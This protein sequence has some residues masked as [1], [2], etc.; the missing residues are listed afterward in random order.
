MH[1]IDFLPIEYRVANSQRRTH[2]WRVVVVA[3]GLGCLIAGA[4]YDQ[5]QRNLLKSQLTAAQ[6]RYQSGQL[7]GQK[8]A[9]LESQL[10][11]EQDEAALYAYL[12]H[13]W[14]RSRIIAE[15]VKPLPKD[16]YLER[17]TIEYRAGPKAVTRRDSVRAPKAPATEETKSARPAREDL[18]LLRGQYDEQ[19]L[20]VTI[21]GLI[22]DEA[23]LHNY[24]ARLEL[25]EWFTS[26][27][28]DDIQRDERDGLQYSRFRVELTVRQGY[29]Q[30]D[31]DS[32]KPP[33]VAS[34]TSAFRP[35]G[36][37]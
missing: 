18:D 24:L 12:E 5:F 29:G 35:G 2:M 3:M 16:I 28:L 11:A 30:S 32:N 19:D 17:L 23:S 34:A 36:R 21:S 27:E 22:D 26:A 25:S 9:R 7:L 4:S 14:P 1:D 31:N 20:I 6:K 37:L 8:I 33:K 13:P 15:I 10:F